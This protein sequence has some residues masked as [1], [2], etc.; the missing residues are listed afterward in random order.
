MGKKKIVTA[1][2]I[3]LDITPEFI[4]GEV[5]S[6]SQLLIPGKLIQMG[7]AS[8]NLGGSVPNVG[9]ALKRMGSD[10]KLMGKVGDDDFGKLVLSR[11]QAHGAAEGMI[12]SKESSTSYSVV[13]APR[14]IDRIF[15]HH[16]GANNDFYEHDLNF[17][18]IEDASLFHFG[19]P[20]IMKS[21]YQNKGAELIAM[22]RKIKTLGVATSLDMASVDEYSQAGQVAWR[23]MLIELL[24]YVDFF[25]PSVEEL[26]YMIDQARYRDWLER[27]D[28]KDVTAILNVERDVKPLGDQLLA[29]GAKVVLIKCGAAGLYLRTAGE[30]KIAAIGSQMGLTPKEWANVEYFERS[31][32]P[33]DIKSASGAGDTS[34]AA[35]LMAILEGYSWKWCLHLAAGTGACCV[36]EY[37]ALSGILPLAKLKEKIDLGWEKQ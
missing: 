8:V 7:N 22:F 28:G 20:P 5:R 25:V 19:Y 10:V 26:A 11:L 24:P 33:D 16:A 31:Y 9:L 14:G 1:G 4:T 2:H 30:E 6:P 18:Q 21:M 36:A 3:C 13:L 29:M 23:D 12:V 32:Q 37:D 34:I 17:E 15:L 27:A 35:F